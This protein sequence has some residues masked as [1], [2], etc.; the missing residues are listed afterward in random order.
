MSREVLEHVYCAQ[1][2][3]YQVHARRVQTIQV[4]YKNIVRSIRSANEFFS[5]L[6]S[7]VRLSDWLRPVNERKFTE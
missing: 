7:V 4:Q 2:Q 5:M 1:F 3:S 6:K